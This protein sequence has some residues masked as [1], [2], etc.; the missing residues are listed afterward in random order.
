MNQAKLDRLRK[1][2]RTGGKGTPRRKRKV[3]RKT[4][5][6]ADKRLQAQLKRLN[7][8]QLGPVDEVNLFHDDGFV[9]HI[10]N[11]KLQGNPNANTFVV[12]GNAEKK[13]MFFHP[14]LFFETSN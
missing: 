5:G 1:Q 2:V 7:I 8:S 3:V 6:G 11:A 9:T 10:T 4:A 14:P 12:S 13:C